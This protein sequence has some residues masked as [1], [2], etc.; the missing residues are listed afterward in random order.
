MVRVVEY[1]CEK[2]I[3]HVGDQLRRRGTDMRTAPPMIGNGQNECNDQAWAR[4][5]K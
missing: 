2:V 1:F 4:Y 5:S 3:V